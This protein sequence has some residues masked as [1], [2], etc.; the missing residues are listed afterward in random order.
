MV[1]NHLLQPIVDAAARLGEDV[2][3]S[4]AAQK[5]FERRSVHKYAFTV[6]PLRCA[7]ASPAHH[8]SGAGRSG[9]SGGG[10]AVF[11]ELGQV[12]SVSEKSTLVAHR[13]SL[14]LQY[15]RRSFLRIGRHAAWG[16]VRNGG[17]EPWWVRER[18]GA[19]SFL[20]GCHGTA[21]PTGRPCRA[22]SAICFSSGRFSHNDDLRLLCSVY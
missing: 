6:A 18:A 19:F 16:K 11:P 4:R 2:L 15:L 10:I 7:E 13:E 12:V 9:G 14:S 5:S 22:S 1:K 20:V 8:S 21:L 3:S 17:D